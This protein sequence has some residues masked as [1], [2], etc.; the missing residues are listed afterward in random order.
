MVGNV[1]EEWIPLPCYA[2]PVFNLYHVISKV[3]MSGGGAF[4]NWY[5]VTLGLPGLRVDHRNHIMVM[6]VEE[7]SWWHVP[8]TPKDSP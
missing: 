7:N 4:P 1:R 3:K 5:V 8:A 6:T 2:P